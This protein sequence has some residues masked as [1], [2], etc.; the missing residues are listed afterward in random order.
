LSITV[1]GN[2]VLTGI[3]DISQRPFIFSLSQNYPNP[4]NPSTVITYQLPTSS[5]VTLM[6]YDLLGRGIATLINEYQSAGSHS[7]TFK[8]GNL[9]SGLYLCRL[10]SGTFTQTR[11]LLLLK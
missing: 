10:Q 7:A 9:P 11:K 2:P 4:F 8:A 3:K 1:V 6:V 5:Q